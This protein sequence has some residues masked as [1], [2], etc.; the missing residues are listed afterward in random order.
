MD[1]NV[2]FCRGSLPMTICLAIFQAEVVARRYTISGYVIAIISVFTMANLPRAKFLQQLLL[3]CIATCISAAVSLLGIW[4]GVK[5]RQNTQGD[6]TERY[7]SSQAAVCAIWLFADIWFAHM[8]RTK[9]P[10]LQIPVFMNSVLTMIMLTYGPRFE[11]IDQG[12]TTVVE[13]LE[14]FFIAF[15]I[16]AGVSWYVSSQFIGGNCCLCLSVPLWN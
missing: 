2:S 8:L 13:F 14:I 11:T 12:I 4:C 1:S 3:I 10:S 5:A 15:G 16:T 6:S 7:N 9:I